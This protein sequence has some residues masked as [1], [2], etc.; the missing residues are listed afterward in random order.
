M[1]S[2][3]GRWQAVQ[4]VA[5][6]FAPLC[7]FAAEFELEAVSFDSAPVIDGVLDDPAWEGASRVEG[8]I[9]IRPFFGEASPMPTEVFVSHDQE[10]L[11]IAF[12]CV[13]EDPA[14]I[15]AAVT[16]R[17][18]DFEND[19][20]VVVMLDPF[21]S[22]NA[23]YYFGANLLGTQFDG[24]LADNG[25]T[26]D[27]KWDATW[28]SVAVRTETGW[29]VEIAI[30]YV[31]GWVES[32]GDA[33]VQAGG[34]FRFRIRNSVF[35]ELTINPDFALIEADLER[36]NLTRFELF[37]HRQGDRTGCGRLA[38][39]AALRAAPGRVPAWDLASGRGLGA[40]GHAVHQAGLGVLRRVSAWRACGRSWHGAGA[41]ARYV[42][43]GLVRGGS[44]SSR[45]AD[46]RNRAW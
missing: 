27:D 45:S 37:V 28:Q 44:R 33:D 15:A 11:Y 39:P 29:S 20:V 19:D 38:F 42:L 31:L 41:L 18:G 5:L 16:A 36:V 43:S 14:A 9:Q 3:I 25:R 2:R 8:F 34:D 35:A 46:C 22:R 7:P 13:D 1:R 26:V 6:F 10:A 4:L 32:G 23:G 17:D 24:R 12:R 40:G 30:L 21:R